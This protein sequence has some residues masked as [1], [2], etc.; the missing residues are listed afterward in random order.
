MTTKY[1]DNSEAHKISQLSLAWMCDQ[2][3]GLVTFHEH[4]REEFFPQNKLE[5]WTVRMSADPFNWGY[6]MNTGGGSKLRTPGTYSRSDLHPSIT[7]DVVQHTRERMHPSVRLLQIATEVTSDALKR[8][9][10]TPAWEFIE[11]SAGNGARWIRPKIE[12]SPKTL[13][14]S[15]VE[16]IRALELDEHIIKPGGFEERLLTEQARTELMARNAALLKK[17]EKL[18]QEAEEKLLKNKELID[19]SE[20]RERELLAENADPHGDEPCYAEWWL[21]LPTSCEK[22]HHGA[23]RDYK[24][25][26]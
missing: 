24:K 10:L 17:T 18:R 1:P 13:F 8:T 21:K 15:G 5:K 3:D 22:V 26:S 14:S 12:G 11:N 16:E 20:K 7:S 2:I 23:N 25:L 19:W 9:N 6:Y 4:C